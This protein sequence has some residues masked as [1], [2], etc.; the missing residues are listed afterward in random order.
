M[1][2]ED[3]NNV[4]GEPDVLRSLYQLPGVKNVADIP[5]GILVRGGNPGENLF[6]LD[7]NPVFNPMHLLGSLPIVNKIGTQE[8]VCVQKAISLP[9]SGAGS[10]L[11]W[12]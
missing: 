2:A 4:L 1:N 3:Y 10:V 6:L 7:G 9:V 5:N 11:L 12:T 8:Y